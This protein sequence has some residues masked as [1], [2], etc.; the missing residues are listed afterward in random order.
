MMMFGKRVL[1]GTPSSLMT[2]RA[3]AAGSNCLQTS[4]FMHQMVSSCI[5]LPLVQMMMR[6]FGKI[7]R[8]NLPDLG[9]GTKEATIK[10]WFVKEGQNIKEVSIIIINAC[11]VR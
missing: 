2:A 1:L 4:T 11:I 3:V 10:E 9:E 6:L 8:I 7:V 5:I